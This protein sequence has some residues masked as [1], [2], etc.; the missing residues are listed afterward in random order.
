MD[1]EDRKLHTDAANE[2]AERVS[3]ASS[4]GD[5][6][7]FPL[8][9][10][11]DATETQNQLPEDK[12]DGAGDALEPMRED[13]GEETPGS[14]SRTR[15]CMASCSAIWKPCLT[16][17]H[18]LPE[19]ASRRQHVTHALMCPPHGHVARWLTLSMTLVLFWGVMWALTEHRALPGGNYFGLIG[20][21]LHSYHSIT[22]LQCV[23]KSIFRQKLHIQNT[24]PLHEL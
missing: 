15:R 24:I 10:I 14:S 13:A 19:G 16:S 22:S 21:N 6:K 3:Q 9:L 8:D 4:E 2:L 20:N 23:H 18:P 17:Q 11:T 7:N 5:I 1:A 12:G